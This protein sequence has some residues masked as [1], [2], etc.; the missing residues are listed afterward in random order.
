MIDINLIDESYFWGNLH[1]PQILEK[2]EEDDTKVPSLL[3]AAAENEA[4]E[5]DKYIA[6]Y[7]DEYL[8]AM[9]AGSDKFNDLIVDEDKKTSPIANMIYYHYLRDRETIT[10]SAG[11]I[12]IHVQNS[13]DMSSASKRVNAWNEMVKFN[14]ELHL[15]LYKEM[16]D[17]YKEI[18]GKID[19]NHDIFHFI[20]TVNL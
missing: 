5:L 17:D 7:Q 2:S 18:Y 11:V 9:F 19:F 14:R 15:E 8:K 16:S 6:K 10:T 1:L 3:D 20:N 4:N 12:R 13:V